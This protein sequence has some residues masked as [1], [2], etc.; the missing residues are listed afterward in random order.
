[1][2]ISNLNYNISVVLLARGHMTLVQFSVGV[3]ILSF[4]P[5]FWATQTFY[6][7]GTGGNCSGEKRSECA[8]DL[9]FLSSDDVKNV[10]RIFAPTSP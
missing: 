6:P 4:L 9:S 1:M 3:R 8:A 5:R 10:R 2:T 7:V